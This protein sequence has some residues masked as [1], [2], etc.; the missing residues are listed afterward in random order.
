[1]L[2]VVLKAKLYTPLSVMY[3]GGVQPTLGWV[4]EPRRAELALNVPEEPSEL[5]KAAALLRGFEF[6]VLFR[7]CSRFQPP[8]E[9]FLAFP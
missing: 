3:A 8:F 7:F 2:L 1:M 9:G 6:S 5:R 4:E